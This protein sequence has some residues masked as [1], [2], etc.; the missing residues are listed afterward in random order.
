ML[1]PIEPGSDIHDLIIEDLTT[2]G[3]MP[4]MDMDRRGIV[5][6]RPHVCGFIDVNGKWYTPDYRA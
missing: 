3:I 4:Q 5:F 6:A 1:S 2:G